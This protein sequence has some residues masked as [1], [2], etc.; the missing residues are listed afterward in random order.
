VCK[1]TEYAKYREKL[2]QS[3]KYNKIV[4]M[5][6]IIKNMMITAMMMMMM[7]MIVVVRGCL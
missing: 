6:K 1:G 2:S 4:R 5:V 3:D 7:M